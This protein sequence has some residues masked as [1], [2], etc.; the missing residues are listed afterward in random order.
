GELFRTLNAPGGREISGL[1][2]ELFIIFISENPDNA[3]RLWYIDPYNTFAFSSS[4]MRL[5]VKSTVRGVR[6]HEFSLEQL[7]PHINDTGFVASVLLK[8]TA[9][10]SGV[11]DLAARIEEQIKDNPHLKQKLWQNVI[12]ALG[13]DFSE[14]LD[15][16]FD[17]EFA[18]K[19][20]ILYLMDDIPK[21]ASPNDD[22]ITG[23]RFNSNLTDPT[24]K[25]CSIQ[26]QN[27]GMI[28]TPLS[29]GCADE[30]VTI[31]RRT[32]CLCPETGRAGYIGT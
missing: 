20:L 6:T 5:E 25:S 9:L 2:S 28:N 4:G 10:G 23:L 17:I 26:K 16:H 21:P 7:V 1:W 19:D 22:R 24:P 30:K 18:K 31:Y 32:D 15:K 14:K 8:N 3:L 29:G 27:S 13:I 12:K 11:F